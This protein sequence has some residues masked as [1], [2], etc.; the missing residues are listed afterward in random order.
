MVPFFQF[1]L[2]VTFLLSAF[3][4][5]VS[6]KDFE[7]TIDKLEINNQ[8]VFTG[9]VVVILL[10]FSVSIFLIFSETQQ[11]AYLIILILLSC[12]SWSIYRAYNRQL[13][14]VCNCFGNINPESFGWNTVVRVILL[15]IVTLY[16]LSMGTKTAWADYS[17]E[18]I[19]YAGAGSIGMLLVYSL[20][21]YAAF[22]AIGGNETKQ[23]GGI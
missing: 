4:K 23:G 10:E 11:L 20:L 17:F 21:P 19:F 8:L 12:F 3:G 22:G 16:L 9:A 15:L 7:K 18:D 2:F 6:F 13:K 5:I 1:L 14:V